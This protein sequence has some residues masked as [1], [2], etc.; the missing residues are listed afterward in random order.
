MSIRRRV[1]LITD[2]DEYAKRAIE[3]VAHEVGGR[4]IT[5][6][7]GNPSVLTGEELVNLIKKAANDPVLVMF[8]DSG[9]VGEGAG[10]RALKYVLP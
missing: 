7:Q 2:G 3:H 5:M 4:C 8:D 9:L 10:E 1:I 6:S